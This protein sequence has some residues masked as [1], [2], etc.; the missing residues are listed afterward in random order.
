MEPQLYLFV[1]GTLKSTHPQHAV[2]CEPPNAIARAKAPGALWRL[3]EGYPILQIDGEQTLLDASEDLLG[4]WAQ[5]LSKAE[6]M[7][8]PA[9]VGGWIEG[10]LLAYPLQPDILRRMDDWE[11]F[12]PGRAGAYQRRVIWTIDESGADRIAWAYVCEAP[13]RWS[14]LVNATRW[15]A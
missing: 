1:Y 2:R 6:G 14:T 12:R 5:A 8:P 11:G 9:H 7:R 4:D 10:E 13:P 15:D 3:R